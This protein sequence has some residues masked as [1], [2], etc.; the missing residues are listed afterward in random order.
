MWATKVMDWFALRDYDRAKDKAATRVASR[1]ARGNV[2]VQNGWFLD[3]KGLRSLTE[4][5]Q[6]AADGLAT[7]R[8]RL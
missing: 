6:V 5:G 8:A 1:Y 3:E 2:S 7:S 4:R